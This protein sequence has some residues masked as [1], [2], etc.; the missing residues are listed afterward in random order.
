MAKTSRTEAG[1]ASLVP[2]FTGFR[3]DGGHPV[4][5]TAPELAKAQFGH[6]RRRADWAIR[7]P[8]R[9]PRSI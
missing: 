2:T 7:S 1:D 9:L 3:E 5:K 4:S 8:F 6:G